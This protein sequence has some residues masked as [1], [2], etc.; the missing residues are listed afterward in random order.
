MRPATLLATIALAIAIPVTAFADQYAWNDRAVAIK[1]AAILKKGLRII[2]YCEPC[3]GGHRNKPVK[4]STKTTVRR[5]HTRYTAANFYEVVVNG[6]AVDLAY[7][8]VEITPGSNTF[9]NAATLLGLKP[10][11]VSAQ[12]TE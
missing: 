12:L 6:E 9:A 4:I 3:K 5:A 11:L 2:E 10:H 1:G 8:F 7:I